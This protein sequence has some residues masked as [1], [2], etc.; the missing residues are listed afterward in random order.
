MGGAPQM[1]QPPQYQPVQYQEVPPQTTGTPA[2]AAG[3]PE[4]PLQKLKRMYFTY[5]GRLNR[6]PYILW[7]LALSITMSIVSSLMEFMTNSHST[8]L[9]LLAL[10]L[11]LVLLVGCVASTM[12]V[13]RRWHDLGK[14][15]WFTL[16]LIIPLVNFLVMLYLWFVRGTVGPNAY[17][18]D[19]LA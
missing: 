8:V 6:K 4:T 10:L 13:I 15:G 5:H 16:I 7:G 18:E 14:S 19:P 1:N 11:L 17:G 3:T 12:L 9:H 2:G